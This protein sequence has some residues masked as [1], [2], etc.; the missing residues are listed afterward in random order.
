MTDA[1]IMAMLSLI[2]T[3]VGSFAGI[4]TSSQ[5]TKWR[6]EQLEKKVDKHNSL[7]EWKIEAAQR[8]GALERRVDFLEDEPKQE[9]H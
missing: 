2:G 4:I 5:L 7:V 9:V 6:I 3:L 1:Q 8:I